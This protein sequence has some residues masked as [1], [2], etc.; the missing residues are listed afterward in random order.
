ME[1]MRALLLGLCQQEDHV[2]EC[3]T[4]LEENELMVNASALVIIALH[5][6]I[7]YQVPSHLRGTSIEDILLRNAS[8]D[9]KKLL[10][11]AITAVQS[12]KASRYEPLIA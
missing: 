4:L 7:C 5:M 6:R 3:L 1:D 12:N 9:A 11:K 8:A 2:V 10:Q